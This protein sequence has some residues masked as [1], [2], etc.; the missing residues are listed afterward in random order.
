[1]C[2]SMRLCCVLQEQGASEEKQQKGGALGSDPAAVG[3]GVAII[4]SWDFIARRK[5]I[6]VQPPHFIHKKLNVP[7]LKWLASGHPFSGG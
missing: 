2:G 5:I 4:G 3:I 7:E 1:M 6:K